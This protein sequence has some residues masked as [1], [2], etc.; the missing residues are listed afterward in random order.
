M[1]GEFSAQKASNADNVS[2]WWRHDDKKCSPSHI[3]PIQPSL[4]G[5]RNPKPSGW[6]VP[7]FAQGF[8]PQTSRKASIAKIKIWKTPICCWK[9]RIF[10]YAYRKCWN[11]VNS[12]HRFS[13]QNAGFAELDLVMLHQDRYC[14]STAC[15][16]WW[17]LCYC[18]CIHSQ[19]QRTHDTIITSL[20]RQNDVAASFWRNNDVMIA[21]REYICLSINIFIIHI[22]VSIYIYVWVY[23]LNLCIYSGL[24]MAKMILYEHQTSMHIRMSTVISSIHLMIKLA[25]ML[26]A[27]RVESRTRHPRVMMTS[28]NGNIF[29][30]TGHLCGNSPVSGEF[31]AQRP[32]TR[33]FD[34][35]LM[36]V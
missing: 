1:T 31:H 20:L 23:A 7:P 30:V 21:S 6:Q 16:P 9:A 12:L 26:Y 28:S 34:V 32:V 13:V 24:F 18:H 3:F 5:H 11:L 29:R 36:S 8:L 2:I 35:F 19:T 27:H 10:H 14:C 4:Q 25:T 33:S 17:P 15:M 22:R